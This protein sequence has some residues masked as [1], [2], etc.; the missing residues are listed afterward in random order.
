M[1]ESNGIESGSKLLAVQRFTVVNC[2]YAYSSKYFNNNRKKQADRKNRD[3]FKSKMVTKRL[4]WIDPMKLIKIQITIDMD[5]SMLGT[6]TNVGERSQWET[7]IMEYKFQRKSI[8]WTWMEWT[9]IGFIVEIGY[10]LHFFLVWFGLSWVIWSCVCVCEPAQ[11]LP[12]H[13]THSDLTYR[14]YSACQAGGDFGCSA[15]RSLSFSVSLD[16]AV[17]Q[18][19]QLFE[20]VEGELNTNEYALNRM[21]NGFE[22]KSLHPLYVYSIL[23]ACVRVFFSSA[24]LVAWCKCFCDYSFVFIF[25]GND[26]VHWDCWIASFVA[27]DKWVRHSSMAIGRWKLF[28]DTHYKMKL[29]SA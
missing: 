7:K 2:V 24:N 17:L 9:L 16:G 6:K 18:L 13:L 8:G 23:Y 29:E 21:G 4:H 1:H 15:I 14:E 20:S 25:N 5:V 28:N 12:A 27:T 19:E 10:F 11:M 26:S 22:S 3:K